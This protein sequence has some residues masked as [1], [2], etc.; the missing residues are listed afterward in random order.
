MDGN[1]SHGNGLAFRL[2]EDSRKLVAT[3]TP[4]QKKPPL[5]RAGLVKIIEAAGYG[6][7]FLFEPALAQLVM[8]YAVTTEHFTLEI[9]EARDATATVEIAHDKMSAYLSVTPPCGGRAL[10]RDGVAHALAQ[11]HVVSGILEENIRSALA[12][13]KVANK[14]V[15]R[16]RAAVDGK[17]GQLL[18]LVAMYQDHQP[19]F[20]E[21]SVANYRDLGGIATVRKGERLMQRI[22]ATPGQ[23]GEN[24]LGQA[25]PAKPSKDMIFATHLKGVARDPENPDILLAATSGQPVLVKNGITVEPV[26]EVPA[27]DLSSGNLTV[28]GSVNVIGDICEGMTVKAS[29]DIHVGGTVEAATLVAGGDVVIKGGIIGHAPSRDHPNAKPPSIARVSCGGTC[30]AHF[31]ENACVEAGDSILVEQFAMQSKLAALNQI[32]VGKPG[33]G[34][35]RIIGGLTEATLLV[36]AGT[37]GS[38]AGIHTRVMVGAN[39]FLH[40][41]LKQADAELHEI[42]KELGEV[43]KLLDFMESHPG[44]LKPEIAEKAGKTRLALEHKR[45]Q[46]LVNNKKL[47]AQ[48]KLAGSA[49][50]VAEKAVFNNVQI[51]I[52]GKFHRVE[53]PRHGGT[54]S[55]REGEIDIG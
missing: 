27:I 19:C 48:T 31:V 10:T 41:K 21:H 14:L 11:K 32:V 17:D 45:N 43:T 16:G 23:S 2:N 26:V 18:C 30:S 4:A 47:V 13:G 44:R 54:F 38:D 7:L 22:P 3:Y 49:K 28:E 55:V 52:N 36:Q 46:L 50:I 34:A 40:E 8:Q 20:D 6:G 15:A 35:G 9:G 29:G 39:P 51:E 42:L 53:Q 12:A 5:D 37:I 24:V 1:I 25:V 33:T